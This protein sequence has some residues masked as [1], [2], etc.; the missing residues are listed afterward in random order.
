MVEVV[1]VNATAAFARVSGIESVTIPPGARGVIIE[2]GPY[3][4][5]TVALLVGDGK[6]ESQRALD[7]LAQEIKNRSSWRPLP[8]VK[9]VSDPAAKADLYVKATAGRLSIY[10]ANGSLLAEPDQRDPAVISEALESITR[11]R[12]VVQLSNEDHTSEL[13]GKVTLQLLRGLKRQQFQ[14]EETDAIPVGPGGEL[15]VSYHPGQ[16]EQNF[17]TPRITNA[18][19]SPVFVTLFA[20]SSDYS[21]SLIYPNH[22][23]REVLTPGSSFLLPPI[24]SFLSPG[25]N[26]SKDYL[27]VFVTRTYVDMRN[28]GQPALRVPPPGQEVSRGFGETSALLELINSIDTGTRALLSAAILAQ[29]DWTTITLP[30]TTVRATQSIQLIPSNGK[31]IALGDG[32]TIVEKPE[33]FQG[34]VKVTT[35]SAVTRGLNDTAELKPPP[36]FERLAARFPASIQSVRRT[37]RVTRGGITGNDNLVLTFE[38][39]NAARQSVTTETPLRLNMPGAAGEEPAEVLAVAFDGEDYLLV[40]YPDDKADNT[41]KIVELPPA[42]P[43]GTRGLGHAIQ[44]FL[45]KKM[46][47]YTSQTGLRRAELKNDKVDYQAV[48]R[49]Q[50]QAGQHVALFVHGFTADTSALIRGLAQ[51]LRKEV[52]PYDHLLTWDYESFNTSVEES[53]AQ[54]ALDLQRLCGFGPNDGITLHVF[55]HGMGCLISRFM[56]EL[57]DGFQ[58]VD[59]LVLAGSPNNGTTLASVTRSATFFLAN[60]VL[61]QFS[62]VPVLSVFD[63]LLKQLYDQ[64][65]GWTDLAVGSPVVTKLNALKEPSNVPYLEL[66]GDPELDG[67][68]NPERNRI[69]RLAQKMFHRALDGLFGEHN[70][71][72]IG[73]SSMAKG[74]RGGGYPAV[75]TQMLT[76]DHFHYYDFPQS[77]DAV[78][79]WIQAAEKS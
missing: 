58:F 33:G 62:A 2:Q 56:I 9:V 23:Q 49:S 47:R 78:K 36:F 72:V 25:W 55:A 44:L 34:T 66:V 15:I 32:I 54:L 8:Y 22:N 1:D 29:E 60:V 67:Q 16:R 74:L 46:G 42:E 75:T 76:C 41:V 65:K 40:G 24:Q 39:E 31:D 51:F 13:G 28:L 17:Y 68:D 79:R 19:Q 18:S 6:E 71:V 59:A 63:S 35:A 77:L 37:G 26:E 61:N 70:D 27:K 69:N 14:V 10:N 11:Y 48:E 20:L 53:G 21:I 43:T 30:V 3:Q 50:F 57:A 4:V 7:L 45:Y 38:V 73:I 12:R 52:V 5:Q 64:G